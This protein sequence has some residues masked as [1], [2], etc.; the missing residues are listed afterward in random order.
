ME[1]NGINYCTGNHQNTDISYFFIK[2]RVD[3]ED[4]SIMY[5]LIHL[6]L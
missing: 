5:C 1:I 3:K 6:M 4:I 2:D